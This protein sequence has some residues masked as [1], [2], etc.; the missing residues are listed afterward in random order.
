EEA[1]QCGQEA[2][3]QAVGGR[4]GFMVTLVRHGDEP[5]RCGTGLAPLAE[6]ANGVKRL[7]RDYLDVAGTHIT[8]AMRRYAGPLI[9][10]ETPG[11]SAGGEPRRRACRGRSPPPAGRCGASCGFSPATVNRGAP[12]RATR[13]WASHGHHDVSVTGRAA[14]AGRAQ[15]GAGVCLGGPGQHA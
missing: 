1:Y 9:R 13:H 15:P 6:V 4:T 8:D 3:R 12:P 11:R 5:Y 14:R 2:V 7:P 10:R